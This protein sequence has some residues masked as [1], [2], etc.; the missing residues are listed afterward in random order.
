MYFARQ[1]IHRVG[2]RVRQFD[3]WDAPTL[4][5]WTVR[6][7]SSYVHSVPVDGT[8]LASGDELERDRVGR[9]ELVAHAAEANSTFHRAAPSNVSFLQMAQVAR[10]LFS[11]NL[12]VGCRAHLSRSW[13]V[14]A[15]GT[16]TSVSC[17]RMAPSSRRASPGARDHMGRVELVA[18][19]AGQCGVG[20]SAIRQRPCLQMAPRSRR[21]QLGPVIVGR[22]DSSLT[23]LVT[24]AVRH[25]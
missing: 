20:G 16:V 22:V 3:L 15:F 4:T 14:G 21:A 24:R 23:Q 8:K 6:R 11:N 7:C 9:V 13:T 2:R 17:L 5:S 18:H 1:A 25:R 10:R 19:A 12:D